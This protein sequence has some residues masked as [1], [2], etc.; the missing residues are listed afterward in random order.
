MKIYVI[1]YSD[2]Y[3]YGGILGFYK[4]KDSAIKKL[5]EMREMDILQFEQDLKEFPEFTKEEDRP[6]EIQ[7]DKDI[8]WYSSNDYFT[9]SIRE[10]VLED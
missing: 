5:Q 1:R 8:M 3:E 7:T 4:S 10:E 9:Y 6:S 2:G